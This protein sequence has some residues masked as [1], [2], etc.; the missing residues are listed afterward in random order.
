MEENSLKAMPRSRVAQLVE[1]DSI[2]IGVHRKEMW[3]V[4]KLESPKTSSVM[5]MTP[6]QT[7]DMAIEL[8]AAAV[9][10]H[11]GAADKLARHFRRSAEG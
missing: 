11:P 7:I 1:V 8:I 4:M 9:H 5:V 2:N 3:V 10:L 6:G